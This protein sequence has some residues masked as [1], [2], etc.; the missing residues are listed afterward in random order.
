[1]AHYDYDNRYHHSRRPDSYYSRSRDTDGYSS[2]NQ[3]G[4]TSSYDRRYAAQPPPHSKSSSTHSTYR[5]DPRPRTLSKWPPSPAVEDEVAALAKEVAVPASPAQRADGGEAKSRGTVDQYPIIQEIE[6]PKVAVPV[7]DL[8]DERRFVLVSDTAP[9]AD[10]ISSSGYSAIHERRRRKSF[11]ERGN[12]AHLKTD[13]HDPPVFTE[14][15]STP[16]VYKPQKDSTAPSSAADIFL[17]PE[18]ITPSTTNIPRSVPTRDQ[19][20]QRD[21]NAKPSKSDSVHGRYDS[22]IQSPRTPKNDVFEDSD[23]GEDATHLRTERKP[24]RYSFVKSDLQKEDLRTSLLDSQARAD[25]KKPEQLPKHPSSYTNPSGSGSSKTSS[26]GSQSPRSSASSLKDDYPRQK[27]R[28]APVETGHPQISRTYSE[29][30]STRP[31]SPLR[32]R[33]PMQRE[34]PPSPPRSPQLPPRRFFDSPVV[35]RPSSRS[36]PPRPPSPLSSS[37][38]LPTPR[39][40]ITEAD[41]HATYPPNPTND[42]PRPPTRP[43]RFE[44]MPVP[45]PR[46]DVKSPSP[47]RPSNPPA[48]LPYPVDDR[49]SDAFMPPEQAYQ[50]DHSGTP[51]SSAPSARPAYPDRSSSTP[52]SPMPPSP[53]ERP[54]ANLPR[55]SI[56]SRH[57]TSP[58]EVPRVRRT[59]SSSLKSQSSQDERR[60]DRK[61][62]MI[63]KP[64]PS[65]PRKE[66]SS[67]YDDWYALD[68]CP[69]CH[70]CPTCYTEVF[71]DTPFNDYF[72]PVRRYG[73]RACD[74][75][76]PWM[77]LAWL[78]T[79]KQQRKSLELLF[80]LATIS[81]LNRQCPND[82]EVNGGEWYGLPDQRDGVYVANFAICPRDLKMTEALFPTIRKVMSRL[83]STNQMERPRQCTLRVSSKRF[84]KYL[85]LLLEI[86]Q[87]ARLKGRAPDVQRFINMA[88]DHANKDECSRGAPFLRR[89]WHFIP[90]LPEFTVCE[91][92]YDDVVWPEI[93]KKNPI[94]RAFIRNIQFVPGEDQNGSSCCLY[95][96]RMRR[97]WDRA[98]ENRDF[99][100]LERKA[101]DRKKQESRTGRKKAELTRWLQTMANT[102][103]YRDSEYERL[104]SDLRQVEDE[105]KRIE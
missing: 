44:S 89:A 95:S 25:A 103:G 65:C 58:E 48:S 16:Y 2:L 1:M 76:S 104:K 5:S 83:P 33:S 81:D 22:F 38:T 74:F 51:T 21:Q 8:N 6:Q 79:I 93:Q 9:D 67:D 71:A 27:T 18:P 19:R 24:A 17:S 41:W 45:A 92:C 90:E 26:P 62:A 37:A 69:N 29:S 86:D 15:V 101:V 97:I 28:P 91:E 84:P 32:P 98:V 63:N 66:P 11:A 100:Y 13:I 31:S 61:P 30:R 43:S 105:W 14:R 68:G 55:P 3:S 53:R 73:L 35:S 80:R 85:D 4:Y 23:S 87:E 64:L 47:A 36:G 99:H 96:D 40:P 52:H 49:A 82:R 94:A 78:L 50:Y 72:K 12:M 42:R 34:V 60:S 59:R 54:L 39:G 77:R 102:G 70:I 75:S 20:D 7:P 46:I 10:D 57:A 88:R 56:P